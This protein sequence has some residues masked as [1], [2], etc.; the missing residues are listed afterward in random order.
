M[1]SAVLTR[2]EVVLAGVA[3]LAAAKSAYNGTVRG[4]V[5]NIREITVISERVDEIGDKQER[6]VDGM[7]ALSVAESKEGASVDTERLAKDLRDGNSY[8]VYLHRDR[9]N[10][11]PYA[12]VEDEEGAIDPEIPEEEL[13]WRTGYDD[14]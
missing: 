13:R 7:V 12:D 3:V 8:R 5:D 1:W 14:D 4:L 6:M 10:G 2:L 9:P 11:S